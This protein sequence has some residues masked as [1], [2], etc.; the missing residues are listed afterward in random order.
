MPEENVTKRLT[1]IRT[2]TPTE[3][4]IA[5]NTLYQTSLIVIIVVTIAGLLLEQNLVFN[6]GLVLLIV[7]WVY[8]LRYWNPVFREIKKAE[9][10]K[11][12]TTI[13][14]K[15]SIDHPFTYIIQKGSRIVIN[16]DTLEQ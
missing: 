12:V 6:L 1:H 10:E 15:R 2:E 4:R 11:R 16:N 7:Q 5:V 8:S 13:G 14:D 9:A 3:I